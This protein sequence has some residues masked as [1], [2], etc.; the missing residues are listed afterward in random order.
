MTTGFGIAQRAV[1]E[2]QRS[3]FYGLASILLTAHFLRL[4][5]ATEVGS[6]V[7]ITTSSFSVKVQLGSAL[8]EAH[9][10]DAKQREGKP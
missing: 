2:H 5:C 4:A 1:T 6:D 7:S 3:A 10:A 9:M 8:Y